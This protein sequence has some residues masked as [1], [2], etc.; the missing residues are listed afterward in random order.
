[1]YT[2][3]YWI[4]DDECYPLRNKNGTLWL[5]ETLMEADKMADDV[6][7]NTYKLPDTLKWDK[8]FELEAEAEIDARVISISGVKE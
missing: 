1:M 8:N 4:N 5:A 7:N 3:I 6:E 2:I